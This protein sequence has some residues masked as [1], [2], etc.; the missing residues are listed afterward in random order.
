M[1]SYN[2]LPVPPSCRKNGEKWQYFPVLISVAMKDGFFWAWCT[3]PDANSR[4]CQQ[5]EHPNCFQC[6]GKVP[7]CVFNSAVKSNHP[8]I[9][10]NYVPEWSVKKF[11]PLLMFYMLNEACCQKVFHASSTTK[12]TSKG[13]ERIVFLIHPT[14]WSWELISLSRQVSAVPCSGLTATLEL[15][16]CS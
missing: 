5:Y 10:L 6:L 14:E 15:V 4:N 11:D 13:F 12:C 2:P 16:M 1:L 8:L 3:S 7:R 9:S